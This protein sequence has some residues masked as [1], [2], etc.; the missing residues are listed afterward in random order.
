MYVISN[1]NNS[2]G[3]LIPSKLPSCKMYSWNVT[4]SII[5][6]R[7]VWVTVAIFI[8]TIVTARIIAV[9]IAFIRIFGTSIAVAVAKA[10]CTWSSKHLVPTANANPFNYKAVVPR[11]LITKGMWG[12]LFNVWKVD[13]RISRCLRGCRVVWVLGLTFLVLPN[14]ARRVWFVQ[15]PKINPSFLS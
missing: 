13:S 8:V 12:T 14:R 4:R 9:A 3:E 5:E 15:A 6:R 10:V 1:W 2:E 7:I 11:S